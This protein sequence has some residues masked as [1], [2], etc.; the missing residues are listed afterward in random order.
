[1]MTVCD[2]CLSLKEQYYA[3]TYNTFTCLDP[4]ISPHAFTMIWRG[5]MGLG[6]RGFREC[7]CKRKQEPKPKAYTRTI[8]IKNAW[9]WQSE[10]DNRGVV[11]RHPV[12]EDIW[13]IPKQ[14]PQ[15]HIFSRCWIIEH[16]D[17]RFEVISNDG[18]VAQ[19]W[20]R[21]AE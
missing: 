6:F 2:D 17:G 20:E 5:W 14:S 7:W 9:R 4:R 21:G 19:G 3:T 15:A 12:Y 10:K 18:W 8:K 13:Y 16:Y 1:M 11:K